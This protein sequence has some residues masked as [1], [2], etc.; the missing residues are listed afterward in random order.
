MKHLKEAWGK[1]VC[2]LNVNFELGINF[3]VGINEGD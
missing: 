2:G 3:L 1:S